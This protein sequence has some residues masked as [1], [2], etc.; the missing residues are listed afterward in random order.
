VHAWV[1]GVGIVSHTQP[2]GDFGPRREFVLDADYPG[3]IRP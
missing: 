3:R 2:I 1:P